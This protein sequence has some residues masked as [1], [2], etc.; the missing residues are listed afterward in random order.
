[1]I[2][3]SIL[4]LALIA[5]PALADPARVDTVS[6]SQYDGNYTFNVTISHGD[7]G[8]EHYVD[9]WRIRDMDDNLL[10][11]RKLAHPHVNEQPFTRSLSGV[12]IPDSVKTVQIDAHDTVSGWSSN[13]K[14]V[15]LP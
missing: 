12:R 10:G 13:V 1:M 11:T 9:A 6:V 15:K 4:A 5:G 2:R 3:N 14:Q 8:W 7:T